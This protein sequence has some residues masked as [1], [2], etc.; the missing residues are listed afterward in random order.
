M[1]KETYYIRVHQNKH[2]FFV[3]TK[4]HLLEAE[5]LMKLIFFLLF[6][7][8]PLWQITE[9]CKGKRRDNDSDACDYWANVTR[10]QNTGFQ[11]KVFE[12]NRTMRTKAIS[13]Q[14]H[15]LNHT[16]KCQIFS[17][18]FPG[19]GSVLTFSVWI[20]IQT[21]WNCIRPHSFD[22]V[23]KNPFQLAFIF[24]AS[25]SLLIHVWEFD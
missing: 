1:N 2:K 14:A 10:L 20:L 9:S 12:S 23:W 7:F 21:A 17:R 15:Q 11:L 5:K 4:R 3:S 25:T 22:L 18:I 6:G 24:N 16:L 13:G 8:R 19:F